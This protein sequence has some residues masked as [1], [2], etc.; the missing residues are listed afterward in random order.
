M[1]LLAL[2]PAWSTEGAPAAASTALSAPA[3]SRT[4]KNSPHKIRIR[5]RPARSARKSPPAR[6]TRPAVKIPEKAKE[7]PVAMPVPA[8]IEEVQLATTAPVGGPMAAVGSLTTLGTSLRDGE[9]SAETL[10]VLPD[11]EARALGLNTK[12]HLA[13]L[14]GTSV[15]SRGDAA[16]AWL[17]WDPSLR[18]WAVA[19]RGLQVVD[20]QSRFPEEE[21]AFVRGPR[22][23]S[24]R[25]TVLKDSLLERAAQSAQAVLAQAPPLQVFVPA[26][27][28]LWIRFPDGLPNTVATGDIL[29]GEVTMAVASDASLDFLC[30]PPRSTVWAKVLQSSVGEGTRAL[31]LHFF[32]ASLAGGHVI[33]IS[34]RLTDAAGEQP[35][36]KVSPGGTLVLGE[37]VSLDP[38]RQHRGARILEPDARLRLELTEAITVTEPPQF[39]PAGAGLWIK[40]KDMETG[41][42]FEVTHVISGRNAE[43]SGLRVGDILTAISGRATARMD[44]GEAL[45]ALYGA[46]GSLFKVTALKPDADKPVTFELKRGVF[47]KDGVETPV[48]LPFEKKQSLISPQ[49]S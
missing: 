8:G 16:Q 49:A 36:L 37:P 10:A 42:V 43:K 30:L 11:S 40:T 1:L 5:K 45:A 20:L 46:P 12:D 47:Y 23:L 9:D 4:K 17:G 24:P 19:R 3:T 41:R 21:P 27:Q 14:N 25:E 18:L 22:E 28:V 32:K 15:R 38:K 44:F 29:I 33:P 26:K 35:L 39:Y 48:P 13:L 7:A 31:R 2:A 34:A 6:Q